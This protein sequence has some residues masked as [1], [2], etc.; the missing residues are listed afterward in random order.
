MTTPLLRPV[1]RRY[2]Q[3]SC[4]V[5]ETAG[6]MTD[7]S[8]MLTQAPLDG[9][10][11][12]PSD[13]VDSTTMPR[14]IEKDHQQLR[15]AHQSDVLRENPANVPRIFCLGKAPCGRSSTSARIADD[16]P[17]INVNLNQGDVIRDAKGTREN[18]VNG[19]ER[20]HAPISSG[21]KSSESHRR[22]RRGC[23]APR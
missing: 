8:S 21:C 22:G 12:L 7:R 23:G 15:G 2:G 11:L 20:N 18:G 14:A 4:Q 1:R 3:R 5:Q 19:H 9:G 13:G 17:S 10:R 6:A 16:C